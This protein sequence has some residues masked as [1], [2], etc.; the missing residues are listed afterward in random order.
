MNN[1]SEIIKR[2]LKNFRRS[3]L[4]QNEFFH[5]DSEIIKLGGKDY[6][7]SIDSYSD[8]DH[9]R[10]DNPF[11]LGVNLAVCTL[12]DIFACGGKPILF[13][14]SINSQDSWDVEYLDSLSKGISS[15][16]EK[17]NTGFIGGDFGYS[18]KWNFSG[19]AIGQADRIVTRKG[20]LPGDILYVTGKIGSGNFEAASHISKMKNEINPFFEQHPVVFPLRIKE[21]SLISNYASS[22]IDTSDGLFKS[23][24]II[25]EINNCGFQISD[26][27]YF[28][29][30]VEYVNS[31]GLPKECL[32][33]GECG[34]YELLFTV[35]PKD[36]ND[37]L[38]AAMEAD[39]RLY[40]IGLIKED[41]AKVIEINNA[42][43][44]FDDFNIFARD[45][46]DHYNYIICLTK[47]LTSKLA[48]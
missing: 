1:E 21:A 6:L 20:A 11:N 23:L 22:C 26:I 7:I 29:P 9:F 41:N 40:R 5:S 10:L 43:I 46:P 39:C 18:D 13:C 2:I 38:K 47:Y 42:Q 19:V 8:E 17:C 4:H 24:L 12:S 33:F 35:N 28:S 44:S 27:P 16:L 31:I 14:N 37:L 25:S 15:I 34:E 30:G 3:P 45:F 36:E 48:K 32:M